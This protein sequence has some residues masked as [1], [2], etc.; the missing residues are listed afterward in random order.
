MAIATEKKTVTAMVRIYCAAHHA[1][2]NP[3]CAACA[4][5]ERYAHARLDACPYGAG[6]P[7]CQACPIHCYKPAERAAMREALREVMRFAGPRM[8]WSHP[9][10]SVAHLW[11]ERF[12]K[13]PR[14]R[15]RPPAA[16]TIP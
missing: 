8:M 13:T 15:K 6:K 10:L 1:G 5:L 11:T 2:G 9:W 7:T 4:A 3:L 14:T 16:P 12:R